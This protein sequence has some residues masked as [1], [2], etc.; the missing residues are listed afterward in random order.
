MNSRKRRLLCAKCGR[1]CETD[2]S[3][4]P[5]CGSSLASAPSFFSL[6]EGSF[7]RIE[8]GESKAR[9]EELERRLEGLEKELDDFVGRIEEGRVLRR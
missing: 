5:S 1:E 2:F 3:Y 9:I 4:C 6:L 8:R 7:S